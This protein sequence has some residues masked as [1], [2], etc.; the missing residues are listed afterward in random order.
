MNKKIFLLSLTF[1]SISRCHHQNNF[2]HYTNKW[3]REKQQEKTH[4]HRNDFTCINSNQFVAENVGYL[5]LIIHAG[6]IV[7]KFVVQKINSKAFCPWSKK[8]KSQEQSV[9]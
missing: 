8:E 7:H 2:E 6:C 9:K 5:S 4:A 3:L 1:F